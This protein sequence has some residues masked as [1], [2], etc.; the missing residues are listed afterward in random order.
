MT[1]WPNLNKPGVPFWPDKEMFHWVAP[2]I[3]NITVKELTSKMSHM[4]DNTLP[5]PV[6]WGVK[7]QAWVWDGKSI[8]AEMVG[9][10]NEYIGPCPWPEG[11]EGC[12]SGKRVEP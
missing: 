4:G 3:K 5:E 8:P 7:E 12:A 2:N 11:W 10:Y 1:G 9:R 6:L